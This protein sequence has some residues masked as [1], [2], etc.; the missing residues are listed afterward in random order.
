MRT[1]FFDP[2][3]EFYRM[4]DNTQIECGAIYAS[5]YKYM[6]AILHFESKSSN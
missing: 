1:I 5:N 3:Y 6:F 4:Y 2:D